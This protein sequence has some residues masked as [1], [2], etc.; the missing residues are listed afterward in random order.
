MVHVWAW[1]VIQPRSL[2]IHH[3]NALGARRRRNHGRLCTLDAHPRVAGGDQPVHPP[4][5]ELIAVGLAAL[6]E[7]PGALG[8]GLVRL[9]QR[10][11]TAAVMTQRDAGDARQPS[12]DMGHA[13]MGGQFH[14]F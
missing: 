12:L 9:D 13:G 11:L 4:Q 14:D 5:A 3:F 8:W 6:A 7:N 2:N 10:P 1:R